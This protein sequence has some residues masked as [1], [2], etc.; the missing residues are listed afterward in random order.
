[1][2][3]LTWA[4]VIVLILSIIG[5]GWQTFFYSGVLRGIRLIIYSPI[6]QDLSDG[7]HQVVNQIMY[8][9]NDENDDYYY[10][11]RPHNDDSGWNG[12]NSRWD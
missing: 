8:G 6:V 12:F 5:L 7:A 2:G 1:M 10:H 9:G 4:V 3:V 11:H